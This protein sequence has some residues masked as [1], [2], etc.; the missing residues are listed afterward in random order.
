MTERLGLKRLDPGA[1]GLQHL[2]GRIERRRR[3]MAGL[4]A[5]AGL[6]VV[7]AAVAVLKQPVPDQRDALPGWAAGQPAVR[8]AEYQS[9]GVRLAAGQQQTLA[10]TAAMTLYLI[11]APD[12]E[13]GREIPT[14]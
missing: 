6:V 2:R 8:V 9:T 14:S 7:L 1:Q 4:Q 11:D 5:G 13:P 3:R 12:R 10:K